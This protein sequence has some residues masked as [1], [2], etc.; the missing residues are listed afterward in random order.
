[1]YLLQ[2]LFGCH[3]DSTIQPDHRPIKHLILNNMLCQGRILT[4][5]TQARWERHLLSEGNTGW[6]WQARQQRRIE[7]T[8]GN[9]HNSNAVASKFSC[10]G[11]CHTYNST[12][13]GRVRH[14]PDLPLEG[15]HR[16]SVDDDS[17]LTLLIGFIR[18]HRCSSQTNSVKRSNQIYLNHFAERRY[19]VRA[20]LSQELL[21]QPNTGTINQDMQT[22]KGVK[23]SQDCY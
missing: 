22:T 3:S 23:S 20:F 19:T 15:S 8:R 2:S 17:A 14:L 12:F 1:M 5:A 6:L 9:R 21:C 18:R 10:D 7:E 13:G 11:Q 16:G 4:W